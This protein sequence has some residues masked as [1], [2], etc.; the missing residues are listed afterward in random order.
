M[1]GEFAAGHGPEQVTVLANRHVV[2]PY[3]G[4]ARGAGQLRHVRSYRAGR[5]AGHALRRDERRSR[6]AAAR[7]PRLRRRPLPGDG[8]GPASAR[9]P[10]VVSLLDVQHHELPAMFSVLERAC[11]PG[12]TT[13]R[14][15]TPTSC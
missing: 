2:G 7:R 15:A 5:P 10:R 1:L 11:G 4:Y 8:A 6:C 9:H 13:A 14:R 3:A 12:P